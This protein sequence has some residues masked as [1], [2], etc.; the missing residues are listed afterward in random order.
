M[1]SAEILRIMPTTDASRPR[2]CEL[3]A[4]AESARTRRPRP[5]AKAAGPQLLRL[6]FSLM[7]VSTT[8]MTIVGLPGVRCHC[9]LRRAF[10]PP[11]P[12]GSVRKIPVFPVPSYGPPLREECGS[13][14][15]NKLARPTTVRHGQGWQGRGEALASALRHAPPGRISAPRSRAES[16]PCAPRPG[17]PRT[18]RPAPLTRLIHS[19]RRNSL[20]ALFSSLK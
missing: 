6:L 7:R 16:A 5:G 1:F 9:V 4:W 14:K 3:P 13:S 12:G 19:A 2:A 11:R 10:R 18:P 20:Y 8:R 15:L 17:A